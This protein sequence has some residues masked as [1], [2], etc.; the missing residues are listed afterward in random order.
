MIA[1]ITTLITT[2]FGFSKIY[3]ATEEN[4]PVYSSSTFICVDGTEMPLAN[5][6]DGIPHCPDSSDEVGTLCRHVVCPTYMYRCNYGACVSRTARCNGLT[7]C[8]DAS[9]E[10]S[11]DRDANEA[12]SDKDFQCSATVYQ[13]CIPFAEVCNGYKD[14]SDGSDENATICRENICPENTFRCSYGGCVHQEVVCDGV[15]DCIDGT[16]EDSNTCTAADC[17]DEECLQYKCRDEFACENGRRC[18]PMAK[19]CDGIR[20]CA[21]ASDENEKLC[22]TRECPENWFRCA[23]GGCIRSELKCNSRLNCHDWSDENESLCGVML[24]EGACRLPPAKP[25]THYSVSGCSRCR[26]GE[27]VPELTRLDYTCDVEGSLQGSDKIYCQNNQW[28]PSIPSCTFE[29]ETKAITCPAP[30][31]ARDAIRQCEAMWGPHKGWLSCDQALPVAL[32]VNGWNVVK[33]ETLPWQAT[34]FSH[35][36][37]QWR[38]F[39][40]GTLI[41]ERV[42]L[43]AGHCVWKTSADTI[44][45][46]FG[47]LSSDLNQVGENAQV[48]DVKSIELQSAYQDHESNYGSDIALL[49]LKKAVTVNSVV[50]PACVPW[51][52]D[53]VLLESQ[54]NGGLGLV[55]GMGLTENDTFSSVLRITTMKIISD[56]E[57][58]QNQK[59]D[60]R[61]Y[62]TYTSFCAGWANGTGVCNG[63]SGGGLVLQRPNSSAWEVHGV[64]SVSPRKLGTNMCDP[65]FYAIFTKAFQVKTLKNSIW[66]SPGLS[67]TTCVTYTFKRTSMLHAIIPIEINGKVFDYHVISTLASEYISIVPK[68]ID[69]GTIDIGYSSGLKI[70]TIRNEG[71]KTTRIKSVPNIRVPIKVHVIIPKLV[72]YHPN[73]IGDFTFVDFPPTIENTSRYDTFVLR[74]LSSR[75][76]NYV[77]LGELDNEVKCIRDID[78]KQYPTFNIFE[79]YPLEGRI[80]PFQ[81][82]IFEVKFS[83]IN[84]LKQWRKEHEQKLHEK[85]KNERPSLKDKD[86]MQFIRIVRIHCIESEDIIENS[87][88]EIPSLIVSTDLEVH[89]MIKLCLYGEV[90]TVQLCFEPD[91]LYFEDLIVGQISQRVLRLTNPSAVALIYLEC[92]PNAAA[93]CYPNW[94]KLNPKASTEVLVQVRGKEN[95]KSSFKLFFNVIADSYDLTISRVRCFKRIKVKSFSVK[96][97]VNIIFKSM[98]GLLSNMIILQPDSTTTRLV[99]Y[100]ADR[101]GRFNGY[102]TYVINDNHS[103]E[104]NITA[105][106]VHKQLHLDKKEIQLGK[107]WLNEEVYQPIASVVRIINKLDA[108]TYFKWE[109]LVTS[110]FYIEP[111]SGF[112]RGNAILH[113]YVYYKS[114]NVNNYDQVIMKCE[115]GSY[116]SL[117]L[118][119]PRF[120][121]KV[122]FINDNTDL[123]EIPLNLPTKVIA[124]LQNFGFNEVTYEIDSALMT[125]GCNVNPPRGKISPRGIVILEIQLVFDVCCRFTTVIVVKIQGCLKLSYKINGTVSF[126]RLK[127]LPQRINMK[128]VS[129]DALQIQQITATNIGT[130]LLKLQFMLE[131]YPEF[132]ISLSAN[133]KSSGIGL[134]GITIVPGASQ[135]FYLHFRPVDLA[136]YAFYLPIVINHLL[137]PVSMLNPK[138]IRTS[139][140]LKS[141]EAHYAHLSG[142]VMT[143]FPDK[144]PTISID[145]TVANRVVFF[146]K[147]SFRFNTVT[148]ELSEELFIENRTTSR[149][150]AMS[151]NIED[152]NKVN[153]PF[154]IKW[155][156]G[157]EIRRSP[158]SIECTL[159]PGDSVFFVLEFKP[160]KR[161]SFSAEA[162]IY[163]RGELD[164]GIFNKLRLDGEFPA[165]SIDVEPTEIYFTPVPLGMGIEEKFR[166]RAKHFDNTTFIRPNFLT[167]TQRCSGDYKDELLRVEFLNGNAISPQS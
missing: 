79:I 74:N 67:I 51:H 145:Y 54:R 65:N 35:E 137:G 91:T 56:D 90:E 46:A 158:D 160:R 29:N 119:A 164:D 153:C 125:H 2:I 15:K 69:F 101:I 41:T 49:I 26:P 148:N 48:I 68:S 166:I 6:C 37:G 113:A 44:R 85:Y 47:I 83:P 144:L 7:D 50:A 110:G 112:V 16:D 133:V 156:R 132:H 131:D 109:I 80:N 31:E 116:V 78:R 100:F 159:R 136:S 141:R 38:F 4:S 162:P 20:H 106:V 139:E 33:E 157:A 76:S 13:E 81:S 40:G 142:F 71:N 18:L 82:I 42:V 12:C 28:F 95:I 11:C 124:I 152:F 163:V 102:I 60:F 75:I 111:K 167:T 43:T 36:D 21:D 73:T 138:S 147:F 45:V 66:L 140:F 98:K 22:K 3:V 105:N 129:I 149:E 87:L 59:R 17:E 58:R 55:G 127:L 39:C 99:E 52:S 115:S 27:I 34:L 165:S 53:A 86:F 161:G 97:T 122:K 77:V 24:P 62:L 114:D 23:Y 32:I 84:I 5:I 25:G 61:K 135:K 128:R 143:P 70:L 92:A 64:V 130:T 108:K 96:C 89:D 107:E 103:F 9:D 120:A 8:V 1:L 134:E 72:V 19:T 151:I 104:L 94:M 121:P 30:S 57:C 126:P 88:M 150:V 155:S 10:I 118:N 146:S 154:T 63:D 117:L 93:R 14:C 123:G